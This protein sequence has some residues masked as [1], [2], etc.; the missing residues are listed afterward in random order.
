M[1]NRNPFHL[2]GLMSILLLTGTVTVRAA[3]QATF[4]GLLRVA[5]MAAPVLDGRQTGD[6]EWQAACRVA[7]WTD[8]VLGVANTDGTQVSVGHADGV[9]YVKFICPIPEKFRLNKVVYASFAL[10]TTAKEKDGDILQDD[11]VGI[12]LMPPGSRDRCFLGINGAGIMRDSKNGDI[13]WNG[14]WQ[15]QQTRDDFFWT[16]EFSVPLNQF[17]GSTAEDQLWGV[18]FAHGG[19]QIDLMEGVWAYQPAE[20]NPMAAMRFTSQPVAVVLTGL[21]NLSEGSMALKGQIA[22][23]AKEPFE[24]TMEVT[25]LDLGDTNKVVFGPEK[26]TLA[27]KPGEKKDLSANFDAGGPL[28]GK[29]L[30]TVKDAKG[31]VLLEYGLPFVFARETSL[32]TRWI[33]TPAILQV[34]LDL[35]SPSSFKKV[36]GGTVKITSLETTKEVLTQTLPKFESSLSISDVDCRKLPVGRYEAAVALQMGKATVNLKDVFVKEPDPEWLG[37]TIGISDKVPVPWTPLKV[38]KRSGTLTVSCWG[39]QY[40][41]GPAGFPNQINVLGKDILAGPVRFLV[42]RGGKTEILPVGSCRVTGKKDA[43]VTFKSVAKAGGVEISAETWIEFDGFVWNTITVKSGS[44]T[45]IEGLSIEIP[46][47]KEYATLWWNLY[48]ARS[49]LT[50]KMGAPPRQLHASE[51]HNFLRLGDE[52]H[53]VQFFYE[54]LKNWNPLPGKGQELVPGEKEYVLRY[55]LIGQPVKLE[56]PLEFAL[57]YMALPCRPRSDLFRRI[58][59]NNMWAGGWNWPDKAFVEKSNWI[60][61]TYTYGNGWFGRTDCNYYNVWNKEVYDQD[62]LPKLK[63]SFDSGWETGRNTGCLYY[64]ACVNDANTPEYRKYRFEWTTVPGNA[65]YV[66]PDPKTRKNVVIASACQ[67]SRSYGD[68]QVWYM[69]KLLRSLSD[70]GKVPIHG[71]QDCGGHPLCMNTLHGCPAEGSYPVLA[72]REWAKRIYTMYKTINPLDQLY[73]HTGGAS[74][75][76]WCGFFDVMIEGEQFSAEYI[77]ARVNDPSLPKDY[78]KIFNLDRYRAECQTYAW[79]P[80]RFYLTQFGE[81]IEKDP[82]EARG[83]MGHLWGLSLLHDAPV[84]GCSPPLCI[85][86]A[87]QELKWDDQVAFIPYWRKQTGIDVKSPVSP[88]V[89]SGWQ[90]GKGSLLVLV[91]NDSDQTATSEVKI[92]F[93]RFGFKSGEIKC[94]DYGGTGLAYPDALWSSQY[95]LRNN[96][97]PQLL[98][99]Q[100]TVVQAGTVVPVELGRR[101]FKLLRFYQ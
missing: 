88:V 24:G 91:F 36:T 95:K 96:V 3:D 43:R 83:C 54:N 44:P 71:Y 92:D 70:N 9:L 56:K 16:V 75:M 72:N 33:P 7:G 94:R 84:W 2:I 51:P 11:Y 99:V 57:G 31:V 50:D 74:T 28:C 14:Q 67:Q 23:L 76:N 21:G 60:T 101:S 17:G 15:T 89:A 47:K 78:T 32:E 22:N 73:I 62:L 58:N 68:F 39:R 46:F 45:E 19:R 1:M 53:G 40:T 97:D 4:S 10:K 12:Y 63:K 79:G 42:K 52:E 48:L 90:R 25:V 65:P 8:P 49:M 13:S 27:L 66:P 81:W 100:D 30:V 34:V 69:D 41:F 98:K 5:P 37:N 26:T 55:N 77:A 86:R 20:V 61:Q 59:A 38:K 80:E 82:D 85:P 93:A 29:A 87:I 18:N 64:Q 35:G 6:A